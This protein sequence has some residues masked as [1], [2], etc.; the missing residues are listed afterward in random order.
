M[1]GGYRGGGGGHGSAQPTLAGVV[2]VLNTS[3]S[4]SSD[5]RHTKSGVHAEDTGEAEK[6]PSHAHVQ[7]SGGGGG[8]GD[9]D[10]S[11]TGT[12]AQHSLGGGEVGGDDAVRTKTLKP[13]TDAVSVARRKRMRDGRIAHALLMSAAWL[14]LAPGGV[15]IARFARK[16]SWWFAL[17]RN[18]NTAAVVAT[19]VAL[20]IVLSVRS[21]APYGTHGTL[22]CL[23]LLL[24]LAQ[25]LNG[26]A[27][28]QFQRSVW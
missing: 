6:T 12:G 26:F 7:L 1:Q 28:K 15:C 9:G 25:A 2:P 11:G 18:C 3:S 23:V 13:R 20:F 8:G 17:H 21:P 19:L 10:G 16:E 4:P 5:V 14:I 22:G 24:A 27:R